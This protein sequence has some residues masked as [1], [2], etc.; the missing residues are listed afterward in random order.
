[1]NIALDDY[2]AL[3]HI[4][5]YTPSQVRQKIGLHKTRRARVYPFDIHWDEIERLDTMVQG[6]DNDLLNFRELLFE[7]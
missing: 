3:V 1:V 4:M 5:R 7:E 6:L 2:D